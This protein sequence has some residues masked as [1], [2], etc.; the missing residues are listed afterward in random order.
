MAATKFDRKWANGGDF[1]D[2]WSVGGS[3]P[4]VLVLD[5]HDSFTYNL[6][7]SLSR[8]GAR[9]SV[10]QA[11]RWSLADVEELA[12]ERLLLSPGPGKPQSAHLAMDALRHFRGSIPI[13]GVCLG[14]QVLALS[15]AAKVVPSGSPMHGKADRIVHCGAGIF[16]G[17]ANPLTVARYHSLHVIPESLP[18][19]VAVVAWS[20]SG[21]IMG[22]A[23]PGEPTWGVQF[24]PE[25]FLTPEGDRLLKSFVDGKI[26]PP[27]VPPLESFAAD[28]GFPVAEGE[29]F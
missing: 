10:R 26:C 19:D 6:V 15:V 17:L 12:P 5:H 3:G 24:H 20:E 21:G 4:H 7:Q 9:I 29:K 11:H 1:A 28:A 18:E 25:S 13:L 27:D 16:E 2:E 14:H 8:T 22:L 23:I